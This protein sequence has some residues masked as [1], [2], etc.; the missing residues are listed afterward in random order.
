MMHRR[1]VERNNRITGRTD[2]GAPLA[3][4]QFEYG[5]EWMAIVNGESHPIRITVSEDDKVEVHADGKNYVIDSEWRPGRTLFTGTIN[6][7]DICMQVERTGTGFRVRHAG[8]L[9]EIRIMSSFAAELLN[10]M[11]AKKVADTSKQLIS[12][13][14]GLLV[15]ID[16]EVGQDVKS[17]EALAVVEAMKMENQLFAERDGIVAKIYLEPGD[18]LDVGQLILELE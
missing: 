10:R 3:R 9:G 15:S 17:G 4:E 7:E 14:P 13:M 12:P 16:V 2:N 8:Y 18:S 1:E 6:E 11:P 5:D